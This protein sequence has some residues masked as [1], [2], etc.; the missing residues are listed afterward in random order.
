MS[1]GQRDDQRNIHPRVFLCGMCCVGCALVASRVAH[2]LSKRY[3]PVDLRLTPNR[4]NPDV[5]QDRVKLVQTG[6]KPD[7]S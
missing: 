2:V 5:D 3:T 6:S 1:G 4:R 7:A